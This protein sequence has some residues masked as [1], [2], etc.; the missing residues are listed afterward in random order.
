MHFFNPKSDSPSDAYSINDKKM[1]ELFTP[2]AF[3]ERLLYVCSR[4]D[5][6]LPDIDRVYRLWR[7]HVS[8]ALPFPVSTPMPVANAA[9]P[10]KRRR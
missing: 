1:S 3:S 5:A 4:T 7:A 2:R 10:R 6:A 8:A 9:S